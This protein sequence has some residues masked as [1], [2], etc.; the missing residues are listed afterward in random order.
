MRPALL[1]DLRDHERAVLAVALGRG[2]DQQH[3]AVLVAQV[4]PVVGVHER[5]RGAT[6][7]AQRSPLELTRGHLDTQRKAVVEAMPAVDV[8]LMQ[9]QPA[10]VVLQRAALE[11]VDLASRDAVVH[12]FDLQKHGSRPVPGGGENVISADDRR[13]DVG[14][15]IG[16]PVVTPEKASGLGLDP[17]KAAPEKLDVLPHTGRLA[18]DGR[19]VA[20]AVE[21][22]LP[23]VRDLRLPDQLAG[24]LVQG[25]QRRVARAGRHDHAVAVDQ[26][27]LAEAPVV[28]A[29]GEHHG[30]QEVLDQASPPHGL[31]G[32]DLGA[33][34][35]AVRPECID[36]IP[37][38]GRRAARAAEHLFVPRR[39]HTLFPED[40]PV[41]GRCREEKLILA[42]IAHREDASFDDG[43]AGVADAEA[44]RA[45]EQGRP[46]LRPTIEE[47]GFG[48]TCITLDAAPLRPVRCGKRRREQRQQTHR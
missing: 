48:R 18:D 2:F 23:E 15:R 32:R 13:R 17:D 28:A 25:D 45:P 33:Q 39:T 1:L 41:L 14:H 8:P 37:V 7:G 9:H 40:A 12:L 4:E 46:A 21:A 20:G 30:A 38:D 5:R 42:E 3:Q 29:A 26:R 47:T 24:L 31:A 6:G 10:M 19:R 11:E 16:D 34:Q 36:A 27:R 43:H 22:L 35:I 44:G